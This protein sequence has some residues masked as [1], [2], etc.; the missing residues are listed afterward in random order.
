VS[1]SEAPGR[2]VAQLIGSVLLLA[3]PLVLIWAFSVEPARGVPSRPIT[4]AGVILC[5]GG[6]G[7]HLLARPSYESAPGQAGVKAGASPGTSAGS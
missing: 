3:A 4:L 2:R 6:A 1:P 7:L 5:L